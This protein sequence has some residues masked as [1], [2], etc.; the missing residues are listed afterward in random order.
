[1]NRIKAWTP[2]L[3]WMGVIF[4]MSAMPG[5]LSGETSGALARLVL[6]AISLLFGADTAAAI[7]PDTLNLFVRKAAHVAEYAVLFCLYRR[8][9]RIE[10]A[11]RPSLC[12]L[13]LCAAYAAT[14]E[15]HQAFV[16][17]RGPSPVDVCIDMLG[18]CM[19]W[20]LTELCMRIMKKER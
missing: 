19:G 17:D 3:T 2:A 4:I 14:D 9:L 15:F 5:D 1:M 18:A 20:G 8:A 16:A 13:L 10:G 11:K 12:A 6:D 7:R